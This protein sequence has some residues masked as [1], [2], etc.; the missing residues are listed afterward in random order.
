MK[1]SQKLKNDFEAI[2]REVSR[3]F[4]D[5][6]KQCRNHVKDPHKTSMYDIMVFRLKLTGLITH[7]IEILPQMNKMLQ[8]DDAVRMTADVNGSLAFIQETLDIAKQD[9]N[10]NVN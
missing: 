10:K 9:N 1:D 5:V 7:L 4:V 6:Y 2:E 8:F 3:I